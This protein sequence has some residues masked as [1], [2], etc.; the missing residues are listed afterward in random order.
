MRIGEFDTVL[1][2]CQ[3]EISE[4]MKVKFWKKCK[5]IKNIDFFSEL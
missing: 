1:G 4:S 2:A 5:A 3:W